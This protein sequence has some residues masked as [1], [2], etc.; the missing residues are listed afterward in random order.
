MTDIY[1]ALLSKKGNLR[2]LGDKSFE[3]DENDN[4]SPQSDQLWMT[5]DW[6]VSENKYKDLLNKTVVLTS[7]RNN[8]SYIGGKITD[9]IPKDNGRVVLVFKE[10]NKLKGIR[11]PNWNSSNPVFYPTQSV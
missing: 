3:L 5:G 11:V 8:P 9:V 2:L 10:N 6:V 4:L 1:I 7:G